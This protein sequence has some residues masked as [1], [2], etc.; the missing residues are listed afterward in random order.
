M[1]AFHADLAINST[2]DRP[3]RGE[4][5]DHRT[6]HWKNRKYFSEGTIPQGRFQVTLHG[7]ENEDEQ[8]YQRTPNENSR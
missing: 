1:R 7:T 6:H 8:H 2:T 5:H 4:S 3:Q